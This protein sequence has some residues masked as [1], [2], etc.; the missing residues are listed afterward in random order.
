MPSRKTTTTIKA[1]TTIDEH[2]VERLVDTLEK[3]SSLYNPPESERVLKLLRKIDRISDELRDVY[4]TF[5]NLY[6][7]PADVLWASSDDV[8]DENPKNEV[9]GGQC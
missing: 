4:Q 5:A 3:A 6:G 1:K 7:I 9:Q 8:D 2:L